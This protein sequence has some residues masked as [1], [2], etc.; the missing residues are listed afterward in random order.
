LNIGS[1]TQTPGKFIDNVGKPSEIV[2][3]IQDSYFYQ[4]F[5]YVVNSEIPIN[6]WRNTVRKVNHPAG[7]NLFG[8]LNLSGGKD[9]SGRRVST[10]F[11]KRVDISEFTNFAEI[12]NFAAAQPI[13]SEYNN[14][15]VI[16]RN[17]R[18]TSS[19]EILTSVVKKIDDISDMFD[20][21]RKSFPLKI[22]GEQVIASTGQSMILINGIVQ[23]PLQSYSIANG[24]IEFTEAPKPPASVVYREIEFEQIQVKR[25]SINNISGI[26][27]EN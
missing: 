20:G 4:D 2:Q 18:L 11:T 12:V 13:Y 17:K 3:K 23:A 9:L 10:D 7:F 16:F 22:Q 19:E 27:P 5:S 25:I 15:E 26:L 1:V 6:Q 24:N 14:S 21:E 8:Q